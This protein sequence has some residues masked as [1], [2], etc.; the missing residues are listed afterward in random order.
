MSDKTKKYLSIFITIIFLVIFLIAAVICL[1]KAEEYYIKSAYPL[2][3]YDEVKKYS[4]EYNVDRELIYSIIKTESNFNK[5]VV[6]SAGAVGLMQIMPSTLE[7][8][9]EYYTG[10]DF[11][12]LDLYDFE[13]N[14]KYGTLY[15]SILLKRYNS[16]S[17]VIC[18]YNAGIGNVDSWLKDNKYSDGINILNTP[19]EETTNYLYK[20]INSE[21]IYKELYFEPQ[22]V[23]GG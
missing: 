18:A 16:K 13:T 20:V 8:L 10:E 19:F 9:T 14:I 3:Y 2:S 12:K 15:L 23:K 21:K 11:N 4:E 22:S 17:A 5:D 6:S 7:W 1:K